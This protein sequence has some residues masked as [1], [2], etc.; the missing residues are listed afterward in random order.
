VERDAR[1]QVT[2]LAESISAVEARDLLGAEGGHGAS[3]GL[4]EPLLEGKEAIV[5]V[6]SMDA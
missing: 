1:Q 2:T 4:L 5:A 6:S 3:K